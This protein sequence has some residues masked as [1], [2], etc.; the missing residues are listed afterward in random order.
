MNGRALTAALRKSL[1]DAVFDWRAARAAAQPSKGT[2]LGIVRR[3]AEA[4]RDR[5]DEEPG[6]EAGRNKRP[7]TEVATAASPQGKAGKGGSSTRPITAF[8]KRPN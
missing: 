1:P 3:G 6:P 2:L 7:R 5:Q 4:Q 8:F